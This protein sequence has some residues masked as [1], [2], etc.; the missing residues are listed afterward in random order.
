MTFTGFEEIAKKF[1]ERDN[2]GKWKKRVP[3]DIQLTPKALAYLFMDDGS[4]KS[5]TAAYYLCTDAFSIEQLGILRKEIN[6]N[7]GIMVNYHKTEKGN[8]R[9]YIP[10]KYNEKFQSL[11]E[12][13]MVESLKYKLHYDNSR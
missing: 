13:Y 7:W 3:A 6:K 5:N 2:Q 4:K 10:K 12:E 1:Y 11:V 8:L 9:L